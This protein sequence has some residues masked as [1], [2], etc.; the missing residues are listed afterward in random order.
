VPMQR[1]WNLP[2]ISF[3]SVTGNFIDGPVIAASASSATVLK[4]ELGCRLKNAV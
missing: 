1:A 3:L 4:T 2:S